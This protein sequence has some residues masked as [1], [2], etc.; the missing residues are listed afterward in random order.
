MS[1]SDVRALVD[2]YRTGDD[3]DGEQAAEVRLV[4][5][6]E[7]E[8]NEFDLNIGRYIKVAAEDTADLG[9]SLV[10]YA[11]ARQRRIDAE[12]IMFERL[13]AAGIDLS[14]FEAAD[15]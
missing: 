1:E 9:T 11:E 15:E 6:D 4:P 3:P 13:A 14:V 10:A 5:Y 12:V 7:I 8:G 2:A